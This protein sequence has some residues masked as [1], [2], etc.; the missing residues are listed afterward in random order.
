MKRLKSYYKSKLDDLDFIHYMINVILLAITLIVYGNCDGLIRDKWFKD[1]LNDLGVGLIGTVITIISVDRAIK[2]REEKK[3]LAHKKRDEYNEWNYNLK[4]DIQVTSRHI[5]DILE[6]IDIIIETSDKNNTFISSKNINIIED[7]LFTK[8]RVLAN[9]MPIRHSFKNIEHIDV[10]QNLYGSQKPKNLTPKEIIGNLNEKLN[11]LTEN[12]KIYKN[13]KSKLKSIKKD[14]SI[15]RMDFLKLKAKP[16][17]TVY[18]ED[19]Q[20]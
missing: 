19:L 13:D 18:N 3:E 15:A 11:S 12:I 10:W 2:Q 14:I 8:I 20:K 9:N 16:F 1:I 4:Q 7:M 5:S 17:E 6:M